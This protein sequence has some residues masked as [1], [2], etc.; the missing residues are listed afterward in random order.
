MIETKS[1]SEKIT[2]SV[3][4]DIESAVT[5]AQKRK[6]L[7]NFDNEAKTARMNLEK[8]IDRLNYTEKY[9]PEETVNHFKEFVQPDEDAYSLQTV[10]TA[11]LKYIYM[12][13][14]ACDKPVR[15]VFDYDPDYPGMVVRRA[16]L[17]KEPYQQEDD[18]TENRTEKFITPS[19]AADKMRKLA[20]KF[21]C[22]EEAC[23]SEMDKLM[24]DILRQLGYGEAADVFDNVPM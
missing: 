21:W 2:L 3:T 4:A 13:L 23:C 24:L 20:D 19:E 22:D 7:D 10:E 11:D 14:A 15:F 16:E 8:E 5:E 1:V 6:L 12:L 9:N 17:L 18:K